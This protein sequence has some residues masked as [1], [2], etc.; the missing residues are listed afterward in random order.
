MS[1][2]IFFLR[3]FRITHLSLSPFYVFL[4]LIIHI[5]LCHLFTICH[6]QS[7]NWP[8]A[9]HRVER[10]ERNVNVNSL[11]LVIFQWNLSKCYN[12]GVASTYRLCAYYHNLWMHFLCCCLHFDVCQFPKRVK[13]KKRQ[14]KKHVNYFD[15]GEN[16]YSV[17]SQHSVPSCVCVHVGTVGC[18]QKVWIK[19]NSIFIH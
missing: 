14:K 4:P 16:I 18:K 12:N 9:A 7:W 17:S 13:T 2:H 1:F 8:E 19:H 10:K 6:V 11:F 3:F 5:Y 15:D